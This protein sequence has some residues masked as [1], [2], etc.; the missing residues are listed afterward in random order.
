MEKQLLFKEK[1][2]HKL[3]EDVKADRYSYNEFVYDKD[4]TLMMANI[5]RPVGLVGK[6]DP[7]NDFHTAM[8]V[9]EAFR[10]LEPIQASDERFW[11]YL[12]HVDLYSYMTK[13]WDA[14][15]KEATDDKVGYI[16]THWFLPSSIQS[17]LLR[18]ALAGLWWAV[19]L[20]VDENR[21]E[22]KYELTKILFR[23]LDFTTRTLGAYNLGR[24]KE[25]IIGILEFIQE[26]EPLFKTRFQEKARFVTR[27]INLMGGVKP[28]AYYDRFF[29]KIE[30]QKI[31]TDIASA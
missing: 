28:I 10:N 31:S 1:Y 27:H 16:R 3:K 29:F 20:T 15:Y 24:H 5:I 11:T 17:E 13:R 9:F 6:L 25:A 7:T 21:K 18:H 26:N 30:L 4:Q 12:T 19:Y 8:S 2:V 22:N 23:Q 14:I